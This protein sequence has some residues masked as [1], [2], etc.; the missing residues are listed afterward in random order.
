MAFCAALLIALAGIGVLGYSIASSDDGIPASSG[1]SNSTC[2]ATGAAAAQPVFQVG[3]SFARPGVDSTQ[4]IQRAID[5]ASDDGGGRVELPSGTFTIDGHIVMKANVE[6]SGVGPATVIK[7]GP[8]FLGSQGPD[9]GYPVITTSGASNVTIANL[10]ADQSGDVLNGNSNPSERFSAYLVDVRNSHNAVVSGVFTRDPFTYSIAVVG[11]TDF[12]VTRCN[13]RVATSGR[14]DGLDGIHILD[15]N[16]GQVI[17]NYVD[18]RIGTDGDDGLVAHTIAAPVF[19]V[20]YAENTVRGG[21]GGDGM[22]LAVGNYP[23]F[24]ITIRDNDFWGSPFGIRTGY[25][26]PGP[27]GSVAGVTISGNYI[28]DLMPGKAF[29]QGGN[30]IDIGGFGAKAPVTHITVTR[31]TVCHAGII[32]VVPGKGNTVTRN[33]T[34]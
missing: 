15:S 2:S 32:I 8:E 33:R 27:N 31:N 17:G 21:S 25:W 29:P 23:V 13:T 1:F 19:D 7:A 10:T 6:L 5:S 16:T 26:N 18:Q 22:Q 30:A 28:H 9:G 20:L 24:D 4:V 14:Y 12:C 3:K 34:C 11:S